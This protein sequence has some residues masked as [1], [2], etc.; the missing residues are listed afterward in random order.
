MND[1][2]NVLEEELDIFDTPEEVIGPK[3]EEPK[4]PIQP[5]I[6]NEDD[7]FG[8]LK[9]EPK[10]DLISDLLK[11]RGI[12]GTKLTMLDEEEKEVEV[13]F[14]ELPR[15][16]QIEILNATEEPPEFVDD[17][18]KGLADNEKEFLDYLREENIS[19]D[20]YLNKY[21]EQ[22]ISE[23][24]VE[25]EVSYDIDAYT[26]EELFL[27][28]LKSRYEDLTDD[29][30]KNELDKAL[31]DKEVFEKKI[32]K[33]REEYKGLEDRYKEDKAIQIEQQKEEDYGKFIDTMVDVAV[34]NPEFYGIELED[35]EKNEILSYLLEMDDSGSSEFAR[36]IND[37]KKLYEAA[38]FLKYGKEAFDAIRNA[39]ESEIR[40]LKKDS[41]PKKREKD[42]PEVVVKKNPI[43]GEQ[44]K[45]I[46][47]LN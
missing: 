27:L 43:E 37:P 10:E 21:K 41:P 42:K 32:I 31:E 26:D 34:K 6:N 1:I 35:D 19:L 12:N 38:W 29:Q 17:S 22:V 15:K 46:Y 40:G 4:E 28:D 16:E 3:K 47:D 20:D 13:D 44:I 18:L 2:D 39:H 45:S 8:E 24:G 33:T 25:P 36:A 14:F 23:A 30:L 7:I 9:E 11:T 5:D